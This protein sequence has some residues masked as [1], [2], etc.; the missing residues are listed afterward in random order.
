VVAAASG[1]LWHGLATIRQVGGTRA[2]ERKPRHQS[3]GKGKGWRRKPDNLITTKQAEGRTAPLLIPTPMKL[4]H[5][6]AGNLY[7]GVET[8]D[9]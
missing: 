3:K 7:G 4:L 2:S 6:R 1:C 9:G 8:T 5:L